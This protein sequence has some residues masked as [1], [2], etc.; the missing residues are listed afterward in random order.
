MKPELN[1]KTL[2]QPLEKAKISILSDRLK[3]SEEHAAAIVA[4]MSRDFAKVLGII[5]SSITTDI[6]FSGRELDL[7]FTINKQN[8]PTGK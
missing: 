4:N 1:R 2:H 7:L 3:T 8:I 6:E 5:E